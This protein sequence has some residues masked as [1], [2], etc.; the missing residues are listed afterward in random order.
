[1]LLHAAAAAVKK[2]ETPERNQIKRKQHGHNNTMAHPDF[3]ARAGRRR[4]RFQVV[5]R[6][7]TP[8]LFLQFCE[9]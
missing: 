7:P 4:R 6:G 2:R 8:D 5:W 3:C 9:I 1:M